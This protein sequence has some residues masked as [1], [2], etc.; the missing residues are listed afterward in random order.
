MKP[1]VPPIEPPISDEVR[2]APGRMLLRV[3]G[4]R[5]GAMTR[6]VAAAVPSLTAIEPAVAPRFGLHAQ[7]RRVTA[8]RPALAIA[9]DAAAADTEY[10]WERD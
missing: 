4:A 1:E 3:N 6:P 2:R 9:T 8:L 10:P 7:A 5:P